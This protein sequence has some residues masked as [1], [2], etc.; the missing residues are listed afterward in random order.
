MKPPKP[1]SELAAVAV[2]GHD[3][4]CYKNSIPFFV[5]SELVSLYGH[6]Y[7]S[8][9]FF[10]IFHNATDHDVNTYVVTQNAKVKVL[11]LFQ[12]KNG[13][14]RVLN[15]MIW[16]E[17]DEIEQF[18]RYVF[19]HFSDVWAINFRAIRTELQQL[20]FPFQKHNSQERFPV[21][22][23][24]SAEEY[25]RQ[26]GRSTR[27]IIKRYRKKLVQDFTDY[28]SRSYIDEEIDENDIHA[29]IDLSKAR[30][31]SKKK[32]FGIDDTERRHIIALAKLC[33]FVHVIRI[34]GRVCAGTINFRLGSSYFLEVIAHDPVFNEYRLGTLC[35]YNTLCECI[36]HGGTKYDFG[37]GR[38]F[39][40]T[41]FLGIRQDMVRVE[42]YR[43][44]IYMALKCSRVAKTL[45]DGYVRRL[46]VWLLAREKSKI[47][48]FVL[49]TTFLMGMAADNSSRR[50]KSFWT[51][52]RKS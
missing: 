51:T 44:S 43:S 34:N 32:R 7:S 13:V 15:E 35:C 4:C 41:K 38:A 29:I 16:I 3:V 1:T 36:G 9:P 11:L 27:E 39:Y 26:L 49:H 12:V 31:T 24:S 5:E 50:V 25:F 20:P 18:A 37:G 48:Q 45:L 14:V 28:S 40:K 33:G 2:D 52:S 42:I 46:K 22:L 21:A 19:T 8:L 47:T 30:I 17:P 23:P 10:R 6:N